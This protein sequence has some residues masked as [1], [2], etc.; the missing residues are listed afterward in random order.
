[1]SNTT[2]VPRLRIGGLASAVGLNTKTIRY[3]ESIGL[4]SAPERTETGYR[5]YTDD[6][7]EILRFI[8]RAKT[9]GLSLAEIREILDLRRA[10]QQP[11][12]HVV[13]LLDEHLAVVKEQLEALLQIEGELVALRERASSSIPSDDCICSIIEREAT[14]TSLVFTPALRR[15]PASQR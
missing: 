15:P 14:S 2:T 8:G 3:Y 7:L 9:V 1:M 11:C 13:S 6:D 4:L 10:G 5:L 12:G